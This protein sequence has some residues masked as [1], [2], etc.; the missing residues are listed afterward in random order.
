MNVLKTKYNGKLFFW[1]QNDKNSNFRELIKLLK[2]KE[3]KN[4]WEHD[5]TF[6]FMKR[7]R[8]ESNFPFSLKNIKVN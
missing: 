8:L 7:N 2:T 6:F 5:S 4:I 1:T 3:V